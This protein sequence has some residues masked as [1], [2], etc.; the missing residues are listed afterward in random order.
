MHGD[1]A[2]RGAALSRSAK[3]APDCPVKGKIEVRV[4]HHDDDVFAA[5]FQ[6]AVLEIRG[7][8]LRHKAADGTRTRETNDRHSFVLHQRRTGAWAVAA[9]QI[10][11]TARHTRFGQD[12]HQMVS[13]KRRI[14]GW[15]Q[16]DR[17]SANE[18]RHQLPRWN[19]HRKIPRCDHSTYSN[20]LAHAHREFAGQFR[21]CRLA[22]EPAAFARHVIRHVDGFLHIAARF[23]QNL[24]HFAGHVLGESFFALHQQLRGAKQNLGAL[25]RGHEP[26]LFVRFRRG[27]DGR[28][29]ILPGRG[30][31]HS[32][33]LVGARWIAVFVGFSGP[34]LDPLA[35]D[36]VLENSGGNCRGHTSSWLST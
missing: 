7:A 28:A 1:A 9:H 35:V 22:K 26:P 33:E 36:K 32:D 16:H 24:A 12:L 6:A 27:V 17:V 29:D 20:R 2:R 25:G 5:H 13:R 30:D 15:L 4:V 19:R 3:S 23:V 11:D 8:G 14:F 34:R 21:R 10:D 31:K 18:R